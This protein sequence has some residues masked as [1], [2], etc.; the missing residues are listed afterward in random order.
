MNGCTRMHSPLSREAALSLGCGQRACLT[1]PVIIA[2]DAAHRRMAEELS[3]GGV[4]PFEPEGAVI[5]YAG[6]A[7]TPPGHVIGPIG[8][9]TS[10]RMDPFTPT[11]LRLGVRG[12][13]GKGRRSSEVIAAMKETGAVYFGATGGAAALLA[14]SVKSVRTLAYEDLG[15]EAVRL[16]EVEDFPLVVAVDASGRDLYEQ[17]KSCFFN[18]TNQL[19]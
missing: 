7:P 9:T 5:F 8:P 15:P 13:I 4:L 12:M 18:G 11:L 16:L 19:L 1:G 14:R 6:P 17:G 3:R 2:R 10:G